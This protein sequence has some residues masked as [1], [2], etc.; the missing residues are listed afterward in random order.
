MFQKD[1]FFLASNK[2]NESYRSGHVLLRSPRLRWMDCRNIY[3]SLLYQRAELEE[4]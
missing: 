3:Q 4:N 2:N 1:V